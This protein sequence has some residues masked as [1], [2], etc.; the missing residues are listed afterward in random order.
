MSIGFFSMRFNI[1]PDM[2]YW[3][4]LIIKTENGVSYVPVLKIANYPVYIDIKRDNLEE[5]RSAFGC[6]KEIV[7]AEM[8]E[9]ENCYKFSAQNGAE[10]VLM[11]DDLRDLF[12]RKVLAN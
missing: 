10:C 12:E 1:R 9:E 4:I 3:A 5:R 11:K 7:P 6:E 8:T 2:L